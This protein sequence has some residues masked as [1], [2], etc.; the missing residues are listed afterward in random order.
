MARMKQQSGDLWVFGYGSLMWRPGF[1][2]LER[3]PNPKLEKPF[4]G[5]TLRML[6]SL[7]GG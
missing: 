1:A 7:R 3:V 6:V 2:F 5:K 4:D